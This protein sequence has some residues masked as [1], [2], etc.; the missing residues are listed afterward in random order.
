MRTVFI[1]A[2]SLYFL[3]S[4]TSYSR[5]TPVPE[6]DGKGA[7]P[8][9]IPFIPENIKIDGS[10]DEGAWQQALVIDLPYETDPGEN[11]PAP[12]TTDALLFY[13]DSYLYI[14][15]RAHDPDPSSI[16]ARY[17]D[18][19]NIGND[20]YVAIFL[21]T[22][23][24]ER[25][26][27]V[28]RSNPLGV[29]SDDI[30]LPGDQNGTSWDAIYDSKGQITDEGYVVEMA[31]PFHQLRFQRSQEDQVWGFNVMRSHPRSK[32]HRLDHIPLD[33]NN[34]SPLSQ[35][36]KI[37]GFEKARPGRNVEI[38]PSLVGAQTDHRPDFP[39]GSMEKASRDLE[40]G[41]SARWGFTPNLTLN[42]TVNPDFSQVEADAYQLDINEPFA[43]WYPEKRPFFQEGFDYFQTL[44]NAVY[45]R[46]MRNPLWGAK[47]SGK[48][49][50]NTLGGYVVHDEVTNFIFPGNQGSASATLDKKNI[51]TVLRYRRDFGRRLTFGLMGT[52]REGD[53]YYNRLLSMDGDIRI[54]NSDRVRFQVMGSS[55]RYPDEMA[56]T[57]NQNKGN[58]NDYYIAFEYDHDARNWGW[59]LDYDDVGS[60]F[61]ADLGFI[62]MV[63]FRNVEGGVNYTFFN[64]PGGWWTT[65]GIYSQFNYYEDR[66][67]HP[68][69][70]NAQLNFNYQGA[71]QSH[72]HFATYRT[73]EY[74]NARTF[75]LTSFSSCF[76][77]RPIRD[78][79]FHYH[80]LFGDR[81]DYDNTRLG[82]RF[83]LDPEINLNLGRH[84]RLYFYHLYERMSAE[85]ARLYTANI[86]QMTAVFHF[87]VRMFF[88][89]ILQYVQYDYNVPNY[90]VDIEPEFKHLFSQ[91][92]FSYK[93]NPFTVFFLGYS[94]NHMRGPEPDYHLRQKNRTFFTKLS[95]AWVL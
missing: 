45:T 59:W 43:L 19:D 65:F 30:E 85:D 36:V 83:R 44:K 39:S 40:P 68:L 63:D 41:L 24:D 79:W 33:R 91:L 2:L 58:F 48:E 23:N 1:L 15:F 16:R 82:K 34:D 76:G 8:H 78:I 47:L 4:L 88:R 26:S 46:V 10:L 5:T 62:P 52:D 89:A 67:Q 31:I 27:F 13:C 77:F 84:M 20:D 55:T 70:R 9:I 21:D 51:S 90:T 54:T 17:T 61:R 72:A 95:Y 53:D 49:G 92:L 37:E 69:R 86:S 60:G 22:F 38:V 75:D 66:D 93:I 12:V 50:G 32:Q 35:F 3:T 81:I 71:M 29:Q 74:Y 28:L 6:G 18:R 25:R 87:N 56:E 42:G 73:E 57:N 64:K 7:S 11:I 80:I 94:D 14:G